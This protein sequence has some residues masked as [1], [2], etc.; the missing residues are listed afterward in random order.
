MENKRYVFSYDREYYY[1]E[2]HFTRE[3]A[4]EYAKKHWREHNC[5]FELTDGYLEIYIGEAK[6]YRDSIEVDS[7]IE[8]LQ[9]E[10]FENTGEYSED[11]LEDMTVEKR[12]ILEKRLTK[13]WNEFKKE[14]GIWEDFYTVTDE[15]KHEF[16]I[17]SE[18][19]KEYYKEG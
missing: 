2:G 4:L 13:V 12:L 3:L 19:F 11:Y 5:E 14:F 1:G 16:N 9:E 8:R 15:K 6:Y 17:Y 18:A 7:I 10:A